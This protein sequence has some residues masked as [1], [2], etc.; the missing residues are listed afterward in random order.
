MKFGELLE[1]IQT[2]TVDVNFDHEIDVNGD[3]TPINL[4]AVVRVTVTS[5]MYGTGDSPSGVD[6]EIIKVREAGSSKPFDMKKL[7]AKTLDWI[8]NKADELAS[9]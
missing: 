5:D 7:P 2:T 1:S 3:S 4:T 6:A 8:R 9:M